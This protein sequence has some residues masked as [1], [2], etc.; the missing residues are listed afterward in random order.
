VLV[1]DQRA[2]AE[3]ISRSIHGVDG[4][5]SAGFV[6]AAGECVTAVAEISPD[7]VV[8]GSP[9]VDSDA[10]VLAARLSEQ[11]PAMR[12]VVFSGSA[13]HAVVERA[14]AASVSA[15]VAKWSPLSVLVDALCGRRTGSPWVDPAI[16]A[17]HRE[18]QLTPREH[19]VLRLLGDGLAPQQ[20]ARELGIT[21]NTTRGHVKAVLSK[22]E[23]HSVLQAVLTAQQ[24][25]LL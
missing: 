4:L 11:R 22:L 13:N 2:V 20:I 9:L 7:V 6:G 1:V 18:H 12:V 17:L 19:D 5:E 21:L 25:G 10:M 14:A 23:S 15:V 3:A 8:V 16:I 24:R